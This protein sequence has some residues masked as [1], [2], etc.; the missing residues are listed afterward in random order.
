MKLRALTWNVHK[1]VGGVDRRYDAQRVADVIAHHEPDVVLLQ[2]V[3]QNSK[4]YNGEA[5]V[6]RLSELLGMRHQTFFVNVK[7]RGVRGDYGNA[8]LSRFPLTQA[9]NT[10][11]KI[12]GKKERSVLHARIRV[13]VGRRS[14]TLH[15]FNMHL[16][17]SGMERKIQLRR[18]LEQR[19]FKGLDE[20]TPILVGGDFNDVWGTLGRLLEPKGF[21]G[22]TRPLPTFPAF[23][24]VRA[25]DSLYVRGALELVRVE[26]SRLQ[27]ARQ[28]S[29]HLPL[30]ADLEA[31]IPSRRRS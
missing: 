7:T 23:A 6:E 18:F 28:A 29:D 8:I 13:R 5:Q 12:A 2:E 11:L 9:S 27:L 17:L 22:P 26:R 15:V 10:S 24:P 16:G 1:C 20:R 14:R 30:I 31:R 19:P 3:A 25:L 4:R 21:R